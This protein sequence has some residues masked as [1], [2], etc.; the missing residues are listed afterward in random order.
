MGVGGA[1][2]RLIK[3]RQRQRR[4]QLEAPRLL[5]LRDGDGGEE[6]F[7][8]RRRIRR[9]ALEQNLAADAMALRVKPTLSVRSLSA[10]TRSIV[11]SAAS[12]SL[13]STSAS[14]SAVAMSGMK[15]P[16]SGSRQAAIAGA[17]FSE[18]GI[19]A[20][21]CRRDHG[22]KRAVGRPHRH[23]VC[24]REVDESFDMRRRAGRIPAHHL[25]HGEVEMPIDGGADVADLRLR[26]PSPRRPC[27]RS[28]SPSGQRTKAR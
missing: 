22:R 5:L 26:A 16:T 27:A 3:L 6:G 1:A 13:A 12:I 10:M 2:G 11:A 20:V 21:Q 17:H 15:L 7:L 14:A 23:F 9:I 4:A 24:A 19:R 18:A 8:G 25:E 28:T